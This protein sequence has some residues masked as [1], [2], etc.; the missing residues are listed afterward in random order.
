[1]NALNELHRYSEAIECFEVYKEILKNDDTVDDYD[2]YLEN[3]I[4][5][6]MCGKGEWI[7]AFEKVI[8]VLAKS[9]KNEYALFNLGLI[10]R[11]QSHEEINKESF[12]S[13]WK[14]YINDE[15]YRKK[16]TTL[17]RFLLSIGKNHDFEIDKIIKITKI[18]ANPSIYRKEEV[19]SLIIK[20]IKGIPNLC[21]ENIFERCKKIDKVN[22]DIYLNL[23]LISIYKENYEEARTSITKYCDL[24]RK[25]NNKHFNINTKKD[26]NKEAITSL[27]TC[28]VIDE[29]LDK[30][31][32]LYNKQRNLLSSSNIDLVTLV[33]RIA[34]IKEKIHVR[35]N[36]NFKPND[37]YTE[38][39]NNLVFHEIVKNSEIFKEVTEGIMQEKYKNYLFD[40]HENTHKN[41]FLFDEQKH[42]KSYHEF[43]KDENDCLHKF[44]ILYVRI[45]VILNTLYVKEDAERYVAHY[46]SC[47]TVEKL[48]LKSTEKN[49]NHLRLSSI[50]TANDTQE[51]DPLL[52]FLGIKPSKKQT[53]YQAFVGCFSFNH[54]SLNQFRL[55]GKHA[56]LEATGV[57]VI[58][59][60]SFFSDY[61]RGSVN[62]MP[63]K[64]KTND[65]EKYTLFRCVYINPDHGVITVGKREKSSF[66]N[67][68]KY[69]TDECK[70]QN[71][72][73]RIFVNQLVYEITEQFSKLKD[74]L[75]EA[76]S[77][78]YKNIPKE[79]D[80]VIIHDYLKTL[81]M[82]LSYLV[83]LVSTKYY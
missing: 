45:L 62:T 22:Q 76:L 83:T 51:G 44:F 27:L 24:H 70:K 18:L 35:E 25:N 54:E 10:L 67:N 75:A 34:K 38:L 8:K 58:V 77:C 26:I 21:A 36:K 14:S 61:I 46:T 57:S 63:L 11:K 68:K 5:Y 43:K 16:T 53:K 7:E 15:K 82:Q 29:S 59:K 47:E 13:R 41:V 31:K 81:F 37:L 50:T 72:D 60:K 23:G 80:Q 64:Y 1:M 39:V 30:M 12:L 48:L 56:N 73:Y 4:A 71:S 42:T 19:D 74:E 65:I 6:A 2:E 52:D 20:I 3:N 78:V 33:S 40:I 28:L 49:A 69:T 79:D 32:E 17:R 55:Y 9:E 66:F